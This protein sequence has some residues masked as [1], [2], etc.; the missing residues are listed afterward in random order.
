MFM[1]PNILWIVG[2]SHR[3]NAMVVV[4]RS[5][6]YGGRVMRILNGFR[7][8]I[9]IV[10]VYCS[11]SSNGIGWARRVRC[12]SEVLDEKALHWIVTLTKLRFVRMPIGAV[13]VEWIR[14]RRGYP[15]R[16][17]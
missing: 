4:G 9:G 15:V 10:E 11:T 7:R 13:V 16:R 2:W 3:A 5:T 1:K 14:V 17:I 8:W 6:L 12:C